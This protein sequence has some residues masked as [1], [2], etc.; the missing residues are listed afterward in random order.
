VPVVRAL[1]VCVIGRRVDV[2]VPLRK[3]NLR[4]AFAARS[5]DRSLRSY[6]GAYAAACW[7]RR[8][9]ETNF[10]P[11]FSHKGRKGHREPSSCLP[12]CLLCPK[13]VVAIRDLIKCQCITL[14]KSL[15]QGRCLQQ[16]GRRPISLRRVL[17]GRRLAQA[18]FGSSVERKEQRPDESLVGIF[19]LED[20]RPRGHGKTGTCSGKNIRTAIV[21]LADSATPCT[22]GPGAAR[23]RCFR[24]NASPP[25]AHPLPPSDRTRAGIA[26]GRW[27]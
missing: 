20:D 9:A 21:S 4:H 10:S 2:D 6:R 15:L 11:F 24:R 8:L 5:D 19:S 7:F 26:S 13:I 22:G 25:A 1:R 16:N 23:S 12:L 27:C 18:R 14:G 3:R 17:G